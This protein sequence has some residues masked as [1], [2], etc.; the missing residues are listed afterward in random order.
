M[1]VESANFFIHCNCRIVDRC[2]R[3]RIN[4]HS[5]SSFDWCCHARGKGA[6]FTLPGAY[7]NGRA[8]AKKRTLVRAIKPQRHSP[9]FWLTYDLL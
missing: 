4:R 9:K 8:P 1:L 2:K 7:A 3:G 6:P 5:I